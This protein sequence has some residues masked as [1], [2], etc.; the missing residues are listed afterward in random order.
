M[1]FQHSYNDILD[2]MGEWEQ[3]DKKRKESQWINRQNRPKK[4]EKLKEKLKKL[5]EK[6][7]EIKDKINIEFGLWKVVLAI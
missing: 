3:E 1:I 6:T 7:E 4:Y 5:E 2:K